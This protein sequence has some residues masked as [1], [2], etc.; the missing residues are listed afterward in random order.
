MKKYS[1]FDYSLLLFFKSPQSV[2]RPT[3]KFAKLYCEIEI[4]YKIYLT[5]ILLYVNIK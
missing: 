2:L 5:Q 3:V 1:S 4:I